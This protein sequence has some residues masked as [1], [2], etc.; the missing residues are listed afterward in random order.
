[1]NR[2]FQVVAASLLAGV[3]QAQIVQPQPLRTG[4]VLGPW[5]ETCITGI[6]VDGVYLTTLA[7]NGRLTVPPLSPSLCGQT[8][9][10]CTYVFCGYELTSTECNEY[11]IFCD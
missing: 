4:Q 2:L 5:S 3:A 7:L 9:E 10:V 11:T 6:T 8:I 1:M